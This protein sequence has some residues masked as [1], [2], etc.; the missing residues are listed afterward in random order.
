VN[1]S[2]AAARFR[3]MA[4]RANEGL[5]VDCAR[6]GAKEYLAGLFVTTPVLTGALRATEKV[7][8]VTGDG[9]H[10]VADVGPDIIYDRFR[11]DGGTIRVKRAKVL[12]TPA[13]GFF[14]KQVTQAGS[15]YM[16]RAADEVE[17]TLPAA[18]KGIA[19]EY[20]TI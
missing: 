2:E 20:F 17:G 12:G 6:A 9:T 4:E 13:V 1:L 14:G 16:E 10:A 3:E 5:A 7:N 8:F 11:N 15:R 19:D 18:M